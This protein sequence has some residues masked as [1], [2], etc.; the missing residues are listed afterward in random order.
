MYKTIMR[1]GMRLGNLLKLMLRLGVCL[2]Q[3]ESLCS[4]LEINF[5]STLLRL[6]LGVQ[7]EARPSVT[8]AYSNVMVTISTQQT[9]KRECHFLRQ[10]LCL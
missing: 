5:Q 10:L 4:G 8:I 3:V 7:S 6:G 2:L 9:R 1:L